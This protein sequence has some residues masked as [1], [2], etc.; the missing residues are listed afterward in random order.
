[1]FGHTAIKS[2]PLN[3]IY[4]LFVGLQVELCSPVLKQFSLH[5]IVSEQPFVHI[6]HVRFK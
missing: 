2:N 6:I 5:K 4:S 1:M 3:E